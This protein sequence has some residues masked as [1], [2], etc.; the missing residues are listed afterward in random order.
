M[1][2]RVYRMGLM[3]YDLIAQELPRALPSGRKETKAEA[4]SRLVEFVERHP[5]L[6]AE[7]DPEDKGA[8]QL[9][10]REEDFERIQTMAAKMNVPIN[11]LVLVAAHRMVEEAKRSDSGNRRQR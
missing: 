2:I 7:D 3:A 4:M 10:F 6:P 5:P 9:K 8:V 11:I 1:V